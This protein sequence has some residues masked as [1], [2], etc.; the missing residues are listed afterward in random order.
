MALENEI[1]QR[2]FRTEYQKA[3]INIIYTYNWLSERIDS[4]FE[5]WD[6]TPRQFNILR[7]LRGEGKPL[8]TLQIRQRM[9]DKM[10]DTSRIVDRLLKK[11]LVRKTPNGED[12]RL[13]DVVITPKGKKLLEKIDP[14]EEYADKIMKNLSEEETKTLNSLLDKLRNTMMVL[15]VCLGVFPTAKAQPPV[16]STPTMAP[17]MAPAPALPPK[18][19]FRAVWVA[20][21]ENI[22]W[23]SKKGL[24]VDS[25]KVEFTRLLDMHKR[26]GMNAV[27]VQIRPAA[28]AF[29]PSPYEPWS[30]WLTGIQGQAPSPY[31]D[32]LEF[33]IEET[34]RRGMEFHAW[35]NPYRAVKTIG[36]SSIAQDHITRQHPE[37]FVRFEN[38]LYFDPG[39]KEVQD[40]VTNVIRD[41]VRRYDI[42]AL[43]FDDYFYP[44]DIVEGGGQGKDFPDNESYAR[45]GNGLSRGDWRR[46]N[47][48]SI[49]LRLSKVI[50]EEKPYCK[51]GISP[52]AIWRNNYKDPEGSAT[53]GGQTDYDNLYADILLWLKQGWIDYVV[54]QIY[55]EFSQPHAPY[56]ALL[57]WWAR[58]SYGRQ[59]YI[60][61][62]I[63][64]AGSNPAW[65]DRTLLTRQIQAMRTYPTVQGAVY[66]SSAS[67][68]NNPNGWCDSL[69]NNYYNYPALIPPMPWIDTVKPHDPQFHIENDAK[70]Q[71]STAWL[72]RGSDGDT[73][74]GFAIYQTDSAAI[75]IDS[76]HAYA[77]IPYDPVAGFTVPRDPAE[78]KGRP[79]FYFV[80][81]IS[82]NNVESSPV[83]LFLSNFT[84]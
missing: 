75:D 83:P 5:E 32:P 50:K 76:V 80:T 62:G 8:S 7:I 18:Y 6:I 38:T 63:Y 69:R 68:Q 64:R 52:F 4:I 23:P 73:L 11:G 82:R 74:R 79:H 20:S 45:Y 43:H 10:S 27:V 31:Y 78:Q 57:D 59:C 14:F 9:L 60:G 28:D 44:Y 22:D 25:Q 39:N 35:C 53:H 58:H 42:D 61:L 66:F 26:N 15:F 40:Y 1:N 72:A 29:Y 24:P 17:V 47:T 54:P 55:F 37:W 70:G 21:V 49:I 46:G 16:D 34:H 33:M 84:N 51:F 12:R 56:A 3:R 19:E 13:V 2:K 77:F 81:A 36:R 71:S 30:E 48:D 67:F 65:R 41:I